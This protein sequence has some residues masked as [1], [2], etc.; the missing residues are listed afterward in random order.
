MSAHDESY[1]GGEGSAR[2]GSSRRTNSSMRQQRI[3]ELEIEELN[4]AEKRK[5]KEI[6]LE[7]LKYSEDNCSDIFSIIDET[8]LLT[9][10]DL[11]NEKTR[12]ANDEYIN[13]W[14][15][16]VSNHRASGTLRS[17]PSEP[18]FGQEFTRNYHDYE[19]SGNTSLNRDWLP[20]NPFRKDLEEHTP[21]N[22]AAPAF[23]YYPQHMKA[24]LGNETQ[25]DIS[26]SSQLLQALRSTMIHQH[27]LSRRTLLPQMTLDTFEGDAAQ[28]SQFKNTF[29]WIIESN[30][31]DPKRRLT[32]LYNQLKGAPKNLI[33]GCL[34]LNPPGY[35]YQKAWELLNERYDD[36]HE[37]TEAYIKALFDWKSIS[38]GDVEGLEKYG[39]FLF[40]V[41]CALGDKIMRLEMRENMRKIVEKL[42]KHLRNKWLSKSAV[43]NF[44]FDALVTF[45]KAQAKVAEVIRN[46][47]GGVTK[48]ITNSGE[49]KKSD[50][51]MHVHDLSYAKENSSCA[52]CKMNNHALW[53]CFKF[54]K[55]SVL[56]RWG[57]VTSLG[58]C[59][60]CLNLGHHHSFCPNKETCEKCGANSHHLKLHRPLRTSMQV[61]KKR[62]IFWSK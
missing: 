6:E 16:D 57:V 9:N 15:N 46:F 29:S 8:N 28:Y 47:D 13:T 12:L 4:L 60:R 10:Q 31:E 14:K 18:A 59:F 52:L 37:Q 45:V 34:H 40:N 55:L 35:A 17:V 11:D 42:P 19:N 25:P 38:N 51:A 58:V 27:E 2:S 62:H 33:Q 54:D 44:S 32:H 5:K 1:N 20:S 50:K 22:P 53:N 36:S 49:Y 21:L 41:Q 24:N 48:L 43:H 30:T 39:S 56:D 61:Q 26:Q 7:K 23:E 3:L